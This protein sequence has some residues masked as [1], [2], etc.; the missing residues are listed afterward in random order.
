MIALRLV[1]LGDAAAICD[2][3]KPLVLDGHINFAETPWTVDEMRE[4]I[5]AA[6]EVLPWIVAVEDGAVAGYTFAR[7]WSP[8]PGERWS[9]EVGIGLLPAARGKQL[10]T[11]LYR[12]LFTLLAAQG[13]RTALAL[14]TRPNPASE[15]LHVRHGFRQV[16]V[17]ERAGWKRGR[18]HDVSYW[19]RHLG[20]D[21]APG[22]LRPVAD[23]APLL[24]GT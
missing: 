11:R 17:V 14:V 20:D 22:A 13:Y 10:G 3:L 16:G 2:L 6:R 12:A 23:V 1:S 24:E 9:V 4:K 18:W 5:A 8:M 21:T 19:Q 15:A 7:A